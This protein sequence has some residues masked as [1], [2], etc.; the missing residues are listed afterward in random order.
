MCVDCGKK[1]TEEDVKKAS[2]VKIRIYC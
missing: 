2:K 1:F